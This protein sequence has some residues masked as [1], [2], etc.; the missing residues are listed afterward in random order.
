M[1]D[2]WRS[3]DELSNTPEFRIWAGVIERCSR[4]GRHDFARYG[5]RGIRVCQRWLDSFECFYA[6]MGPRPNG[7]TLDRIDAAGNYAPANCRW[8]TF[9]EQRVNRVSKEG[10]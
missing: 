1:N 6:D 2:Y 4:V 5:G 10:V 7:K 3:L 9:H 8:A